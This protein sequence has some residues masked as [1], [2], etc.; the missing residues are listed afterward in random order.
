MYHNTRNSTNTIEQMHIL[1]ASDLN[2]ISKTHNM[3]KQYTSQNTIQKQTLSRNS[4]EPEEENV[5]LN[6]YTNKKAAS[7]G[8]LGTGL[9]SSNA[10]QLKTI[11]L[12]DL[13]T[14]FDYVRIG[15]IATSIFLQVKNLL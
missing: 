12:K 1:S 13:K 8:A 9:L 7:A 11:L 10:D 6:S 4:S 3:S 15:L 14:D 5:D 2:K